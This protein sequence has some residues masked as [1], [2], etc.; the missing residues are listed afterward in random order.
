MRAALIHQTG[1]P[2]VLSMEEVPDP[3]VGPGEVLVDIVAAGLNRADLLRRSG[4]TLLP[5]DWGGNLGVEFSGHVAETGAR[6]TRWRRGDAVM[7]RS[8]GHAYARR[9]AVHE[10]ELLPVPHGVPVEDAASIPLVW[11][12]AYEALVT[13]GG[14]RTGDT[15]LITA[16]ASGVGTAAIQLAHA[17]GARVVAVAS[18]AKLDACRSL[19]ADVTIDYRSK[20]VVAECARLI[21]P[22]ACD[23]IV[24]ML[25]GEA[26]GR[27][28]AM[29]APGGRIVHVG[30][31]AGGE[32]HVRLDMVMAK[33]ATLAAVV[34]GQTIE[35]RVVIS[36]RFGKQVIP[37]FERGLVRPVIDRRFPFEA[38]AEAHHH[39]ESDATTG[40]V[41]VVMEP[42]NQGV[43]G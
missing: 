24:D 18:G 10:G 15:V 37:L 12:T 42:T 41:I 14:M 27:A 22:D 5:D 19:G 11:I 3:V 38:I 1:G 25:G 21:G 43:S 34:L 28:L 33:R 36:Q 29:L 32:T 9:I 35:Q 8:R 20:D 30:A 13:V 7:A 26:V 31:M 17:A 16:A 23:V 39:L 2:E 40:K 6:V 4:L